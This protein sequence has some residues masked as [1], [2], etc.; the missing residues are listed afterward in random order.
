MDYLRA[1]PTLPF[2]AD[3]GICIDPLGYLW[4][5]GIESWTFPGLKTAAPD[6]F[7]SACC[8]TTE[9]SQAYNAR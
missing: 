6:S 4:H 2:S 3:A 9:V 8:V 1:V 7:I 5:G